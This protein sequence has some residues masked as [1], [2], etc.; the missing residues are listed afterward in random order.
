MFVKLAWWNVINKCF[1]NSE[2]EMGVVFPDFGLI[3]TESGRSYI[4]EKI[5][6]VGSEGSYQQLL[7]TIYSDKVKNIKDCKNAS[8]IWV[9]SLYKKYMNDIKNI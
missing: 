3:F 5:E 8:P 1:E 4:L 6:K 7:V 9:H 2:C